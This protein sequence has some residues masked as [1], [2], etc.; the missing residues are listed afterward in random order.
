MEAPRPRAGLM[1]T[2]G[3]VKAGDLLKAAEMARG[4]GGEVA[5]WHLYRRW[6]DYAFAVIEAAQLLG[7]LR[8][9][10]AERGG[11]TRVVY[12][13]GRRGAALLD[14]LA[15]PCPVEA[16]VYRGRLRLVT[17]LGAYEAEHDP[18]HLLS[19][20]YKLAEA[21]GGDPREV[22]ARLRS[23][24]ERAARGARG[25]ERWLLAGRLP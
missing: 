15:D 25:L 14:M 1:T 5:F 10:R 2:H 6:G 4:L 22:A 18:G 20:A 7:V 23:A 12:V 21:C 8:W 24:A 9:A 19:L 16:Y 11:R 3:F 17:P 13:L